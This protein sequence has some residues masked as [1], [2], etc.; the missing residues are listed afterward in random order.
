VVRVSGPQAIEAIDKISGLRLEPRVATLAALRDPA[1][2]SL[3]DRGLI[4][5]FPAPASFTGEDVAEFH[6]HGGLA[7][8]ETLLRALGAIEGLRLA[9]PGEFSRRAFDN[10]KLDLTQAEGLSDLIAAQTDAQRRLALAQ[11]GG[12]LR[13]KAEGWRAAIVH[14]LAQVEADIDF[15]D[16]GDVDAGFDAAAVEALRASVARALAG[17]AVGE[18]IRDG[19][20]VAV[21]GEPNVGKSSLVNALARRDVAIVSE[22]AGTTRDAIEVALD[23][24]GVAVTL[25]DTA[26]LRDTADPVEAEG[27]R[28]ARARAAAAELVLHVAEAPPAQPLGQVVVNKVDRSRIAAGFRDGVLHV[29]VKTGD[30]LDDLERWLADWA[31]TA[32]RTDEPPIVARERQR[33]ALAAAL[34]HLTE[35]LQ[36]TDTVLRAEALRLAARALGRVTG[37]VDVE[38][39]LGE[40]FGRFCIGK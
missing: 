19:L 27:I 37:R 29:S 25:I 2:D 18:R 32:T 34:A 35:A 14:L 10:G 33:E 24:A 26:G 28:R 17:A 3:I 31:T 7:V 20:T 9:E 30:G 5:S 36:E 23:L 12:A 15:S 40:I 4:L 22:V 1:D 6:V 21:V 13:D 38:E 16:Q 39:V 8:V 11:A